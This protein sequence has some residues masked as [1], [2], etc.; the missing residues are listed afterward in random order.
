MF[1]GCADSLSTTNISYGVFMD[2]YG[3][4]DKWF[5]RSDVNAYGGNCNGTTITNGTIEQYSSA[6]PD[7]SAAVMCWTQADV[8]VSNIT[9]ITKTASSLPLWMCANVRSTVSGVTTSGP[10]DARNRHALM[11]AIKFDES[12][13]GH[14]VHDCVISDAAAGGISMSGPPYWC[15][16][17]GGAAV[18]PCTEAEYCPSY[19]AES[20]I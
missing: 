2:N 11:T 18:P 6:S 13:G 19:P 8:T 10:P 5:S 7:S 12:R 4:I 16:W 1:Y 14:V 9:L 3:S 20:L 15:S 17:C